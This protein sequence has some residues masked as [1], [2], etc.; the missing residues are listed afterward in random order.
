MHA[1]YLVNLWK[2]AI[3]ILDQQ[4]GVADERDVR[5]M[6]ALRAL[7]RRLC[8]PPYDA[9]RDDATRLLELKHI[10][11]GIGALELGNRIKNPTCRRGLLEGW[12]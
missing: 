4:G 2:Q 1:D 12:F 9:T 6:V 5:A 11:D 7:D 8:A 3:R 10:G